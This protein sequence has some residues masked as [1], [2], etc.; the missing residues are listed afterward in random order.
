MKVLFWGT[1]TFAVPSLR[2]LDDEGFEIVGV[3]TQPDRPAGRGQRLT[4]SAVK[5]VALELGLEV[6]QPEQPKTEDFLAAIRR[7]EPDISVVVAYGRIL[8]PDVLDVPRLGSINIHASLLPELRGAAPINWAVARGHEESGITIM[9][10][11]EAMDAG[12]IIYQ[13][14]ERILNDETAGELTVRLSEVGAQALIEALALM[15]AG[16]VDEIE[17]DHDAATYAPKV[18]RATARVDWTRGA[19]AV[20]AHVR[21][22]D[23]VPGAWSELNGSPVK[24]YRP[25]VVSLDESEGSLSDPST[26]GGPPVSEQDIVPGTVLRTAQDE[27]VLVRAGDGAVLFSEVQPSG[28]RRMTAT[29]WI[30][31]RGV[32]PGQRF[33]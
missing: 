5:E 13:V 30:G 6:L 17:Q 16:Q 2:A 25:V 9:R 11:V 21:G 14:R 22:M 7:L 23:S 20:A 10:M 1:S 8:R 24:L 12:A 19:A 18:D 4:P 27:G 32:A 33:E 31:G 28:S 26:N 3:V 29:D 15:T